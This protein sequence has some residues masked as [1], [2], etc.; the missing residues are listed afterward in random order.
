MLADL[1]LLVAKLERLQEKTG[2]YDAEQR[3]VVKE[4]LNWQNKLTQMELAAVAKRDHCDKTITLTDELTNKFYE[5][6][7]VN[8][9]LEPHGSFKKL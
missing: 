9:F 4:V 3:K 6:L 7:K 2:K 5:K 8:N 1:S